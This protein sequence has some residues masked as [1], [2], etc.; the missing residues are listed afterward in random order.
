[1][2][3]LPTVMRSLDD[4]YFVR[5]IGDDIAAKLYK[6]YPSFLKN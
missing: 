2:V 6:I 5:V 1:M 3:K 4:L